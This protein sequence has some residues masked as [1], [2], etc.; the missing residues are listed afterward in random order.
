ML[1]A[2]IIL[3]YN[4]SKRA[5]ELA[6]KTSKYEEIEKIIIVDNSSSDNSIFNLKKIDSNKIE[7]IFSDKNKGFASGNNIGAKYAISQYSPEY[8]LFANT[9]TIFSKEDI[10][11]CINKLKNDSS[12]G[13]V[14]MRM[15]DI[16]N[17][18][19]RSSW[20]FK[21]YWD[22]LFFNYWIYKHFTYKNNTYKKYEKNFQY[23]DIVRGSYM[24]F[25]SKALELVN[26]FDENTFLYYEEE[27]ISFKLK[28]AGYNI[29]LL[30]DR[31]YIHNHI[32]S[33]KENLEFTKKCLDDSL[34]YFL[35]EYYQI[36][37]FEQFL[38]KLSQKIAD[39]ELILYKFIKFGRK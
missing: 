6:E 13:L 14:S 38:L 32:N 29:G 15:K 21:K 22:Y 23:V 20:K 17:N 16:N 31:W 9:D 33:G 34:F 28:R 25:N 30:T 5:I 8:L 18:E 19:E 35:K 27:I 37:R 36:N 3:N 7:C 24:L 1:C 4:D 12:L 39:I 10:E 2:M 26:F 11:A